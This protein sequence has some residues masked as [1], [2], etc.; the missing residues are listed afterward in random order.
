MNF[1]FLNI[2]KGKKQNNTVSP[3]MEHNTVQPPQN[4]PLNNGQVSNPLPVYGQPPQNQFIP[5]QAP[6]NV[7]PQVQ[8]QPNMQQMQQGQPIQQYSPVP[9][10]PST[11]SRQANN[12]S[13]ANNRTRRQEKNN[14]FQPV[15]NANPVNNIPSFHQH[16]YYIREK[17][18]CKNIIELLKNNFSVIV[19]MEFLARTEEIVRCT[20]MLNGAAYV[21]N[22]QITI[23]SKKPAILLFSQRNLIVH[24]D[25][26]NY[27]HFLRATQN[28]ATAFTRNVTT[29]NVV[30]N[31]TNS[32]DNSKEINNFNNHFPTRPHFEQKQQEVTPVP[33]K[34]NNLNN[35]STINNSNNSINNSSVPH[36]YSQRFRR[37]NII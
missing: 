2:F 37:P 12:D 5:S 35:S 32:F 30:S 18:E 26:G 24:Q 34:Q 27:N 25:G 28:Q 3:K 4:M 21:L 11:P 14:N 13:F 10:V 36:T 9:P 16:I 22:C 19:S 6:T 33:P 15:Y 1:S 29:N 17:V 23:I 31:S 7:A 20:D 8:M